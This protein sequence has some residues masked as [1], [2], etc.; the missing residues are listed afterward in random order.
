MN[1]LIVISFNPR[2]VHIN[3]KMIM[4]NIVITDPTQEIESQIWWFDVMNNG[5]IFNFNG[6]I[7]RNGRRLDLL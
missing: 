3:V 6:Q 4:K 7:M 1:H 5:H 2:L